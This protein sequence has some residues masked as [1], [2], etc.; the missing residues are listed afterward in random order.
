M[1]SIRV[2]VACSIFFMSVQAVGQEYLPD[3]DAVASVMTTQE[4][5]YTSPIWYTPKSWC[6]RGQSKNGFLL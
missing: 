6:I 5:A 4:R 3:K 1:E 2:L